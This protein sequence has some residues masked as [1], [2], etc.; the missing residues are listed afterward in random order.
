MEAELTELAVQLLW[1]SADLR[2][3]ERTTVKNVSWWSLSLLLTPKAIIPGRSS[4]RL[5][6]CLGVNGAAAAANL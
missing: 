4:P 5:L 1:V 3:T 6:R 2:F